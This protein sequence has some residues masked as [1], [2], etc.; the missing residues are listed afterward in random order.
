MA[1][2]DMSRSR[3][4]LRK[5]FS[6]TAELLQFMVGGEPLENEYYR[7]TRPSRVREWPARSGDE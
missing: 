6:P 7:R 4:L 1:M 2:A 5:H 3:R